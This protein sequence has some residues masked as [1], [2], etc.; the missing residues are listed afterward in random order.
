M[1]K[2][3]HTEIHK[4]T[5]EKYYSNKPDACY[6]FKSVDSYFFGFFL[7]LLVFCSLVHLLL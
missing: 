2:E 6:F 5:I 7:K 4:R 3:N 1:G